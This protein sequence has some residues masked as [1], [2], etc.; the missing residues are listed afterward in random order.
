MGGLYQNKI[1]NY[2]DGVRGEL[3]LECGSRDPD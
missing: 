3:K 1:L 2:S